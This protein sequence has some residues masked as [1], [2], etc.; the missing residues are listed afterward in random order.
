[1]SDCDQEENSDCE[2]PTRLVIAE[3]GTR[4]DSELRNRLNGSD[5]TA[6]AEPIRSADVKLMVKDISIHCEYGYPIN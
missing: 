4:G 1:M 6:L 3:E 2:E 5:T